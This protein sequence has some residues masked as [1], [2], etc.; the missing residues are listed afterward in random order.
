MKN[1]SCI[2][3]YWEVVVLGFHPIFSDA[4]FYSLKYSNGVSLGSHPPQCSECPH[5][6]QQVFSLCFNW[7]GRNFW[8]SLST[9]RGKKKGH[10]QP[11]MHL[12]RCFNYK[13]RQNTVAHE[14]YLQLYHNGNHRYFYIFLQ[15]KYLKIF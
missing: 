15:C 13:C 6:G 2:H 14:Q 11:L 12:S 7:L 10:T 4:K 8:V 5:F 3:K 1:T 9:G